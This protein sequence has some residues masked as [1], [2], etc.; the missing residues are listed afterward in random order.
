M[1]FRT[2]QAYL[3]AKKATTEDTPFG[4]DALVYKVMG[5][6]YALVAWEAEPLTITLKCEPGQ[7]LFLR[8][9]Y[10]AVKP[11][12]YMNKNHWNTITVDGSIPEPELL[13]MI[14]DSY[15]LV[16]SGLPRAVRDDLKEMPENPS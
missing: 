12:Y 16:V 11:G 1:E 9:V 5:K 2:L 13:G 6:M 3:M 7:A 10:P 15:D 4:P 14:D 8:D